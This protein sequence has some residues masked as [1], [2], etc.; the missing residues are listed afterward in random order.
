MRIEWMGS[1]EWMNKWMNEW[2]NEWMNKEGKTGPEDK[3]EQ[4]NSWL[5][6]DLNQ[7]LFVP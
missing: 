1:D 6:Q 5:V 7:G 4:K 2:M 3:S